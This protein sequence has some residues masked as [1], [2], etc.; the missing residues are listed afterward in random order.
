MNVLDKR[1]LHVGFALLTS[2]SVLFAAYA[3][4]WWSGV[5]GYTAAMATLIVWAVFAGTLYQKQ[6]KA[7]G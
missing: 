7:P 5:A 2:G 4:A 6:K 3:P 1:F